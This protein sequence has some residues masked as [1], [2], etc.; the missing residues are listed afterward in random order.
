MNILFLDQFGGLGGAQR[1]LLDLLPAMAG[2][3]WTARVAIPEDG[4][5]AAKVRAIG[6]AVDSISSGPY[7]STRKTLLDCARFTLETPR[8]AKR[9]ASLAA[10]HAIHL[11]YVNGPRLLPA[12]AIVARHR[13]V[14]LIFHCHVHLGQP[15]AIRAAGWSLAHSRATMIGCCH[16]AAAPL[17]P[18]MKPGRVHVVYNG[19]EDLSRPK[20]VPG[21]LLRI[22]IVGRIEPDKGQLDFVQAAQILNARFPDL[23]FLV[24]G[25]PLFSGAAYFDRVRR[26]AQGLPIEFQGWRED[27][28]ETLSHTDLLIVPSFPNDPNPRVIMEAFSARVPVVAFPSGGIPEILEDGETGFLTAGRGPEALASRIAEV[29]SMD[30]QIGNAIT[31]RARAAWERAY[32]LDRFQRDIAARIAQAV[33]RT[34]S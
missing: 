11:L 1:C 16:F 14:P 12:S 29:L 19:T 32:T 8:L 20:P 13:R 9:I 10:S 23:R 17:R 6:V 25:A 27:I 5:L 3:G 22:A 2:H 7:N 18:Y 15:A 30:P 33:S 28:A 24:V 4:P 21:R 34:F 26:A 31:G